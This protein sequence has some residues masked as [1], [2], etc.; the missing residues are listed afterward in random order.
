MPFPVPEPGEVRVVLVVALL[1]L[2]RQE[3]LVPLQLRDL[4]LRVAVL[5]LQNLQLLLK[6]KVSLVSECHSINDVSL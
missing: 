6:K 4:P 5:P 2:D 3:R 1:Q